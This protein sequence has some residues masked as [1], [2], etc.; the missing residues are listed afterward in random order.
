ME[1][2]GKILLCRLNSKSRMDRF[3]VPPYLVC[4]LVCSF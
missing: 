1:T 3:S 2:V 4:F